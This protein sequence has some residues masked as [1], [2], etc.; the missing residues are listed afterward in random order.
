MTNRDRKRLI[1]ALLL[2]PPI[3][4]LPT[5]WPRLHDPGFIT[6]KLDLFLIFFALPCATAIWLALRKHR[7][8]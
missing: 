5:L 1:A 2:A 3:I 7:R 4:V 6:R 8:N